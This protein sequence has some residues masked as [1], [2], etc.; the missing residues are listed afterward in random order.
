MTYWNDSLLI[1]VELLDNEHRKLV[2][3]VDKLMNAC[4]EGKGKLEIAQT[5]DFVVDY[6]REHFR[7]EENLQERY[8]Y[9]GIYAHKRIHAQFILT[10]GEIVKEFERIGPNTALS[11]K[12]S[13]TLVEWLINHIGVEDKK[14]GEHI[15][16]A[17]GK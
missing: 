4:R 5:L 10:I 12:L 17:G 13:K 2:A 16:K 9:P 15:I 14:V 6:T 1:G 3:A 8:A 11:G 7:D